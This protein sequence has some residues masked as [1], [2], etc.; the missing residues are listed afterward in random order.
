MKVTASLWDA[1]SM[2]EDLL[3][4][5][6]APDPVMKQALYLD[7]YKCALPIRQLSQPAMKLDFANLQTAEADR[8][9]GTC[10]YL[11]C[12]HSLHIISWDRRM[13]QN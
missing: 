4:D 1:G 5:V 3:I 2:G 9:G 11:C 6:C 13:Y 7:V 10:Q 8:S 12:V